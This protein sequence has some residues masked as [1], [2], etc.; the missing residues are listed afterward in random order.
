MRMI[1]DGLIVVMIGAVALSVMAHDQTESRHQQRLDEVR[2]AMAEMHVKARV[3]GSMD[4]VEATRHGFSITLEEQ[5]FRPRPPHNVLLSADRPW[6]DIAQDGDNAQHPKDPVA[7]GPEQAAFW[8]NPE[9]GI[10]RAR[11]APQLSKSETLRLY[12][13]VNLS[14]LR[15]IPSAAPV[16]DAK[17]AAGKATDL[18]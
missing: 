12:N 7:Y 2:Q 3:H 17:L 5:W 14:A 9:Y 13:E 11:V 10:I 8:Y 16:A 6:L 18:H 1:V 4:D 15:E